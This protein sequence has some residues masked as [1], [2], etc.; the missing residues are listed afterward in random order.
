MQSELNN[1][2]V[3][4]HDK[5]KNTIILFALLAMVSNVN[6]QS[7][8]RKLVS[9]GGGTLTGGNSQIT[10]SIGETVVPSLSSG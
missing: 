7:I 2:P 1:G 10:F 8:S 9:S 4:K 5:M 3:I 6:A